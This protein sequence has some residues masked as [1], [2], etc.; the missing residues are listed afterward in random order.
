MI[1]QEYNDLIQKLH[2]KT[3]IKKVEWKTS[4]NENEFTVNFTDFILTLYKG[5]SSASDTAY[6][7]LNIVNNRG[8]IID[9]IFV[10]LNDDDG[11]IMENLYETARRRAYNI[12]KAIETIIHELD[13]I[14]EFEDIR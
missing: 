8:K 1:P 13:E 9:Q 4:P 10:N 11:H 12:D 5:L 3:I 7:R 2:D 6:I 14:E